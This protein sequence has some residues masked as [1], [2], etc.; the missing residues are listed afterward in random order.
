MW[1]WSSIY[2]R[3]Q[4]LED[5]HDQP[6]DSDWVT[7]DQEEGKKNRWRWIEEPE[8]HES[9]SRPIRVEMRVETFR[10]RQRL[11][12]GLGQLGIWWRA[13]SRIEMMNRDNSIN[14]MNGIS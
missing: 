8:E 13:K 10:W 12:T 3:E 7:T 6:L 2:G 11:T 9:I 14:S 5:D 1:R 4:M